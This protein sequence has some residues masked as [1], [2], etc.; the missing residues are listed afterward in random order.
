MYTVYVFTFYACVHAYFTYIYIDMY[1]LYIYIVHSMYI[2]IYIQTVNNDLLAI[3]D[4][5][6]SQ[7]CGWNSEP[8]A[9]GAV[10]VGDC[11]TQERVEKAG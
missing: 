8:N 9:E 6:A 4:L 5:P 2:Y 3:V 10:S 1:I 7:V 11:W